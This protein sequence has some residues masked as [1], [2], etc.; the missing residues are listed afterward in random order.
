M[1]APGSVRRTLLVGRLLAIPSLE[2]LQY[3]A[4]VNLFLVML[5]AQVL[6]YRTLW[7]ALFHPGQVVGGLDLRMVVGYSVLAVLLGQGSLGA[8][9]QAG[10]QARIRT[11]EIVY[12]FLR[13]ISPLWSYSL[14]DAGSA[15][16]TLV[17]VTVGAVAAWALGLLMPPAGP[18]SLAWFALSLVVGIQI[19]LS[20]AFLASLVSFWTLETRA[21]QG[22]YLAVIQ[23]LS[24]ALVPLTFFPAW[25]L[26]LSNLLP[27]AQAVSV[28]LLLYL[29]P[30]SPAQSASIVCVQ[31]AWLV[32][33][34]SLAALVWARGARRLVVQGG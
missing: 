32:A 7:R 10:V 14:Q 30:D 16:I 29:H 24:R 12:D 9:G 28:P 2:M 18:V 13:P 6:L 15:V 25:V 5:L 22:L 33:L 19:S 8:Q 17:W 20:L 23:V 34:R 26:H 27:F 4:N 1:K 3:Q 21:V 31:L 11:G